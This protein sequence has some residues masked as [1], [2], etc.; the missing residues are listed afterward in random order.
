MFTNMAELDTASI[1]VT[2]DCEASGTVAIPVAKKKIQKQK[3]I[4]FLVQTSLQN[5]LGLNNMQLDFVS[6]QWKSCPNL[7]Q[8][9]CEAQDSRQ[10]VRLAASFSWNPMQSG[11]TC[12]PYSSQYIGKV[13]VPDL[14]DSFITAR[15]RTGTAQ[16]DYCSS[17]PYAGMLSSSPTDGTPG[18]S[19][20][21]T[22]TTRH[23]TPSGHDGWNDRINS[24]TSA[25]N[26]LSL[27]LDGVAVNK[28]KASHA[29]FE[30][31]SEKKYQE[32]TKKTFYR[33]ECCSQVLDFL[34][35][36]NIEAAYNEHLLCK[37]VI[38][39]IVDMSNLEP[40]QIPRHRK[41]DCPCTCPLET[42]HPRARLWLG[43][44]DHE[45]SD[46]MPYFE[47]IS[48][49]IE[50]ARR[51]DKNVLVHSLDGKSRAVC[52]VIQYLMKYHDM[53]LRRAYTL[54][55]R[56]WPL[57]NMNRGFQRTLEVWERRLL[58]GVPPSMLFGEEN[59]SQK[60]WQ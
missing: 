33:D 30:D 58:P 19:V 37:R 49:F 36:G 59:N 25:Y 41:S 17:A 27:P 20:P 3:T 44:D 2:F 56:R 15:T 32:L 28:V 7:T 22:E 14:L 5:T 51:K 6:T 35:I 34:F 53:N 55:K 46:V 1:K 42:S 11:Q 31:M 40:H 57:I 43:V 26:R 52:G 9:R 29:T 38:E 23:I 10:R 16:S 60:A 39:S 48:V 45:R 4:S 8:S 50:A 12:A 13:P 24:H 47:D 21:E 18:L 54:L